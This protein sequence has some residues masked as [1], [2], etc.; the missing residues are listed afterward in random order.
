M[1]GTHP[2][3]RPFQ[4]RLGTSW[5]VRL[6]FADTACE[7]CSF[8]VAFANGVEFEVLE[9]TG[10]I[11]PYPEVVGSDFHRRYRVRLDVG[12]VVGL[13]YEEGR[14]VECAPRASIMLDLVFERTSSDF[15]IEPDRI[16]HP[17]GVSAP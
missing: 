5:E 16:C 4:D 17:Q 1:V 9:A 14:P 7:R 6:Q 2:I 13:R 10:S 15:V 8:C 11:A 3:D 12:D